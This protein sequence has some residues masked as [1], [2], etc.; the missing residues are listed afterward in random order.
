MF[1]NCKLSRL[2]GSASG[3]KIENSLRGRS[4]QS[5]AEVLIASAIGVI[6]IGGGISVIIPA[7]RGNMDAEERQAG[8]GIGKELMENVRAFGESN[9][10]NIDGLSAGSSNHYYLNT[11]GS[12]STVGGEETVVLDNKNYTRYFFV[13]DAGRDGSGSI[14]ESGAY[15]D[16][17]TKKITVTYGRAGGVARTMAAYLTRS[18]NSAMVQTDWSG[19]PGSDGPVSAGGSTA[20]FSSSTSNVNYAST[21][22]S[23]YLNL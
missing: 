20:V 2:A 5:I 1:V 6:L 22:G 3:G 4:G 13:E 12:F 14:S 15:P 21:T 23:I 16:P 18:R 8:T 17:S 10:H 7:L 9:W 19:G 11:E